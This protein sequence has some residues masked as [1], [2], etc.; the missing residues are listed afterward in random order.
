MD[1]NCSKDGFIGRVRVKKHCCWQAYWTRFASKGIS[2]YPVW[3]MSKNI[4]KKVWSGVKND[5]MFPW[6]RWDVSANTAT[7]EIRETHTKKEKQGETERH[8]NRQQ[9]IEKET[10][11]KTLVEWGWWRERGNERGREEAGDVSQTIYVCD[12]ERKEPE[13]Q[14]TSYALLPKPLSRGRLLLPLTVSVGS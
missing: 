8:W 13:I 11:I 12:G 3:T 9:D 4:S 5:R 1:K 6:W 2:R 14:I 10:E 7:A